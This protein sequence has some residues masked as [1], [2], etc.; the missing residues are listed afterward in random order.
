MNS[1]WFLTLA[2]SLTCAMVATLLQQWARRYLKVTQPL[3][4]SPHDRARTHAFFSHGV[5]KSHL[6]WAVEALAT[7][8]HLSLFSFF[9]GLLIYLFNVHHAVFWAV[10]WWVGLSTATYLLITF[11]PIFH[12]ESPYHTPLSSLARYLYAGISYNVLLLF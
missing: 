4:D 9:T 11:V 8:I 1:L 5:E 6:S 12:P 7:L 3:R 2:I 10:V